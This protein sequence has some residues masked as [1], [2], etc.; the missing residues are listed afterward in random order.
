V[1]KDFFLAGLPHFISNGRVAKC[2]AQNSRI[3]TAVHGHSSNR[4]RIPHHR[5]YAAGEGISMNSTVGMQEGAVNIE[6][7]GVAAV[8]AKSFTDGYGA[9][10]RRSFQPAVW[11]GH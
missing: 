5:F 4:Y 1:L 7:V 3:G 9:L 8:P 6:E 11:F 2:V 10:S